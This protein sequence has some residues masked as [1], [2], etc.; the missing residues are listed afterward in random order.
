MIVI[1]AQ[2]YQHITQPLRRHPALL[3]AMVLVNQL[4][5]ICIYAAYPLLLVWL[6]LRHDVRFWHVL[7]V[8]GIS[9]VLLSLLRDRI[10]APRPYEQLDITPLIHKNTKGHSFPSRHVF[11][12]AVISTAFL[13]CGCTLGAVFLVFSLLLAIIRVLGGVHFPRDVLTGLFIGLITGAVGFILL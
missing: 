8:P 2:Q 5:T 4:I 1:T 3:R 10:N 6:L 13:Y 9:F 12:A 11:S 7:L